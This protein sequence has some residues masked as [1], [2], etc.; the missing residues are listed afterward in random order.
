[1]QQ[2]FLFKIS[3]IVDV[4][5]RQ[6]N[7]QE[8]WIAAQALN[9]TLGVTT[10]NGRTRTLMPEMIAILQLGGK[11]YFQLDI[12]SFYFPQRVYQTAECLNFTFVTIDLKLLP[13]IGNGEK[14]SFTGKQFYKKKKD[15]FF[16]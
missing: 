7:A 15:L 4:E 1:M 10:L 14:F 6:R 8:L 2:V 9:G 13:W 11:Y 12:K 5:S 3:D 16:L